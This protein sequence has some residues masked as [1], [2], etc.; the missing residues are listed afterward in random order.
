MDR[1]EDSV[2]GIIG[3]KIV[4]VSLLKNKFEFH[5]MGT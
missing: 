4:K 2:T 5:F 3:S 1:K